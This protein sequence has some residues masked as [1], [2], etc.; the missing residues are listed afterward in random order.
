MDG[1]HSTS[2]EATPDPGVTAGAGTAGVGGAR[3]EPGT[4]GL[5]HPPVPGSFDSHVVAYVIRG[6]PVAHVM[7][8]ARVAQWAMDSWGAWAVLPSPPSP[9][10]AA[11]AGPAPRS[12]TSLTNQAATKPST[13]MAAPSRN[14]EW[15]PAAT[16]CW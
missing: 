7:R 11:W 2:R 8:G 6:V 4:G 15:V 3:E 10:P 13:A 1:I 14:A 12:G 9:P 16:A 5:V